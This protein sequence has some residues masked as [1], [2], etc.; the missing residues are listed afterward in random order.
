MGSEGPRHI[1]FVAGMHR[2]GTSSLAGLYA[3]MGA[4]IG[5]SVMPAAPDN[6]KGFFENE[7]IV[8]AHTRGWPE[9]EGHDD[10][11]ALPRSRERALALGAKN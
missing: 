3:L 11:A 8:L 6:P 4:D 7:R 5:K 10:S 9:I 1:L 2:S